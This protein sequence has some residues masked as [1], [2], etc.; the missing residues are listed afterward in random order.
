[1]RAIGIFMITSLPLLGGC[2][3]GFD[4]DYV[5]SSL[6]LL[7]VTAE[8]AEVPGGGMTT[9][10]AFWANPGKPAPTISWDYCTLRPP[11]ASGSG[12]N[13]D[14]IQPDMAAPYLI[15]IGT[16]DTVSFTMPDIPITQLG[17]PDYTDGFYL[18]IRLRL[19]EGSQSVTAIFSLRIYPGMITPNPPNKNPTL[20]GLYRVPEVDAGAA[21]QMEIVDGTP[22]E[23]HKGDI[24]DL[25]ALLTAD[26]QESYLTFSGD[27]TK[28]TFTTTHNTET[29]TVDWLVTAG[30]LDHDQTGVEKPTVTWTLDKYLPA[31]GTPVDLWLVAR[32]ER[33]GS[34][35][36]HRSFN[37]K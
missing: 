13:M 1:M 11:P 18:P 30:E 35:I 4:P 7:D 24:V 25:R 9:M 10:K 31:P 37:F 2:S 27:P 14:C 12:V 22:P 21:M 5:I 8:P 29:V 17:L 26:A 23:L 15:A 20:M 32:D 16:G 28:G 34:D 6:R 19:L 3:N 33:G 36:M